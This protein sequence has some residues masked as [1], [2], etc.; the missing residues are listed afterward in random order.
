MA[1]RAAANRI[2]R[3][4]QDTGPHQRAR[5]RAAPVATV[6]VADVEVRD[7]VI[8]RAGPIGSA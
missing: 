4:L 2:T 8:D 1:R 3:P 5:Y 6:V 7:D